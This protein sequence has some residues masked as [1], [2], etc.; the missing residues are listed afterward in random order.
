MVTKHAWHH[1]T[2]T[3][4]QNNGIRLYING[5]LKSQDNTQVDANVATTYNDFTF[6]RPNNNDGTALKAE[7]IKD[8]FSIWDKEFSDT[9]VWFLYVRKL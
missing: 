8:E 3:W 9:S 5:C 7:F 1:V 2:L 6:G 4:S